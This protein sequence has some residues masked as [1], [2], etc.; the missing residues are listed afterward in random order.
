MLKLKEIFPWFYL[1]SRDFLA[2]YQW[3]SKI[4]FFQFDLPFFSAILLLIILGLTILSSALIDH[5]NLFYHQIVHYIFAILFLLLASSIPLRFYQRF[6]TLIYLFTLSL[7]VIV[8]LVGHTKQGGQRWI[9]LFIFNL[10]SSEIMKVALPLFLANYLSKI[11]SPLNKTSL[12][13]ALIIIALPVL[14]I[15]KEPDLGTA[16]L[17]MIS[18]AVMIFLAGISFRALVFI[19]VIFTGLFGLLWHFFMHSYQKNRIITFLHPDRDPLNHGYHILQS[20]IAIGSG[21]W[22]GKGLFHGT[23]THLSFLPENS[24]DF[25]FAV[26]SEELGLSGF[27]ILLSL[28]VFFGAQILQIAQ[29]AKSP[30]SRLLGGT[31]AITIALTV[32]INIAMVIGLLPVVG[33]PLPFLSYGGSYLISLFIMLGILISIS[34]ER[35]LIAR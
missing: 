17:L 31:I 7:L 28:L 21:G 4:K 23:Q 32:L 9:K 15:M 1:F 34:K 29:D 3:R 5:L 20:K 35:N 6:A 8:L 19:L 16:V 2:E 18:G 10:Q 30:F 12:F 25:I 11:T 27:L 14:L 22:L 24:T 26:F 33:I 13:I